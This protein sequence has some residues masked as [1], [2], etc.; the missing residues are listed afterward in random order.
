MIERIRGKLVEKTPT[1]SVVEMAG[2]GLLVMTSVQTYQRLGQV[3][4]EVSLLTYLN[5]REDSL[6]LYG[7][8]T[9]EE[10]ELFTK[11][12]GVS[13]IGPRVALTVLSGLDA[14]QFTEV[15]LNED[16]KTLQ[17]I[18]GIGRKTAQRIVL[19]LR[20]KIAPEKKDMPTAIPGRVTTKEL[21]KVQEAALALVAL[22]YK[23]FESRRAVEK[24]L[25]KVSEDLP[26]EELIIESLKEL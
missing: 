17:K 25:A 21:S 22:G 10:R 6:Q 7:F 16:Y 5:V 26:L 1:A 13:G 14:A 2:L 15:V 20:E 23:E 9:A 3:G 24:A 18:P 12:I 8:H 11:L 4:E 19:E